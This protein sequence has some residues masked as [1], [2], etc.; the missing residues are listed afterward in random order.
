MLQKSSTLFNANARCVYRQK[1]IIAGII[2]LVISIIILIKNIKRNPPRDI[3]RY[4]VSPQVYSYVTRKWFNNTGAEQWYNSDTVT[5][6]DERLLDV[7]REHWITKGIDDTVHIPYMGYRETN[8]E[9]PSMGQARV[10]RNYFKNKPN[11]FFIECG[12]YDGETRS[13]TWV[14]E[15]QLNWTGILI[16]ADPINFTKM[17]NKNRNAYMSPTCLS[18]KK[19]PMNVSFLMARNIGRIHAPHEQDGLSVTNSPDRAYEGV[20]VGVQCFPLAS[21]IAA[22]GIKTVDYFSLDIEGHELDVL[23]TIPFD[24][25]D[26]TTLSVEFTHVEGGQERLIKFMEEK[27][28]TVH[29]LVT[30]E[31]NLANDVIF[32]KKSH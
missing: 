27:G 4:D 3:Y 9:D 12:A 26:I 16:E 5:M 28:Y 2:L 24:R 32:V 20:H 15:K 31:D 7:L 25:V 8:E 11:G 29:D 19:F 1:W 10:I 14:L 30:N 13:N 17:L 23:K 6:F 21:Y 22:L 18:I